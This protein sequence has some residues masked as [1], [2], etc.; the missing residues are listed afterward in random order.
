MA[1]PTVLQAQTQARGS[2]WKSR[3]YSPARWCG[4]WGHSVHGRGRK[5]QSP[6]LPGF[7]EACKRSRTRTPT[8]TKT[9]L[10]DCAVLEKRPRLSVPART[11]TYHRRPVF[12]VVKALAVRSVVQGHRVRRGWSSGKAEAQLAT[13]LTSLTYWTLASVVDA[14]AAAHAAP[15][16][17]TAGNELPTTP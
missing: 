6:L 16:L 11:P 2:S 1:L 15:V 8:K 3:R 5:L 4:Y 10:L 9:V 12:S 7:R 17:P 14:L 13:L